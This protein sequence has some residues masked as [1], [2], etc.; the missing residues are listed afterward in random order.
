VR[1]NVS[2]KKIAMTDSG[3]RSPCGIFIF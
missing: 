2:A 3:E 1:V